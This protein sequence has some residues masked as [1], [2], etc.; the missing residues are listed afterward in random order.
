METIFGKCGMRCDLCLIY[1][2]NVEHEDRR[3][4][5]CRVWKKQN[6]NFNGDPATLVCDGCACEREDA[7]SAAAL[8]PRIKPGWRPTCSDAY[9]QG[10]RLVKLGKDISK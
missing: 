10:S 2:P 4:E 8:M 1:R 5:I 3:T 9:E 6:L 7:K